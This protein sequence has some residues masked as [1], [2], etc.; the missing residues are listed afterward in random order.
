MLST[1]ADSISAFD[2]SVMP[3]A[4][5]TVYKIFQGLLYIWFLVLL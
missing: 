5:T 1:S 3:I 4:A 2:V